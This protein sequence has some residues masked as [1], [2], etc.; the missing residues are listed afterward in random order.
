M[1]LSTVR[2]YSVLHAL[3]DATSLA[4]DVPGMAYLEFATEETSIS[5]G[6]RPDSQPSDVVNRLHV[7]GMLNL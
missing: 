1:S 2:V 7:L 6:P 3:R 5:I 4:R